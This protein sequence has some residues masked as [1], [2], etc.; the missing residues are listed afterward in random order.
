MD[1]TK[2][3]EVYFSPTGNTAGIV[4]IV[5]KIFAEKFEKPISEVDI[6]KRENREN[7]YSFADGDLVVFGMPIYAGRIPNKIMPCICESFT[8]NG[9]LAIAV[10]SFGNRSYGSGLLELK[11][12]LEKSGFVVIGACAISSE[13]AF[14]SAIGTGRPDRGDLL[15]ISE[16]AES[17]VSK[18]AESN[19]QPASVLIGDGKTIEP[20]YIPQRTDGLPAKFLK[21]KPITD[22][23]LCISCGTCQRVC[24][25]GSVSSYDYSIVDGICIKCQ[26]C[27]KNCPKKAKYFANEDFLSHVKMLEQNFKARHKN[28]FFI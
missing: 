18:V 17:M 24:P 1:I 2:V 23:Q 4:K 19:G 8:G 11:L 3:T 16:F 21:A 28:S 22:K 12:E 13:H 6:T 10:T 25:M 27:I 26:A 14:S 5:A 20:Y 15:E 7:K 9:A